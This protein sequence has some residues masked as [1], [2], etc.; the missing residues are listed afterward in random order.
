MTLKE[1]K[2]RASAAKPGEIDKFDRHMKKARISD[3]EARQNIFVSQSEDKSQRDK[4]L[5]LVEP[6][7]Y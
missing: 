1:H 5:L 6:S 2:E 7:V 4:R 3:I